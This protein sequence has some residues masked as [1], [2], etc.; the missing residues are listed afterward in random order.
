MNKSVVAAV[1][2]L[3][4][5]VVNLSLIEFDKIEE[6]GFAKVVAALPSLQALNLRGSTHVGERTIEAL[7][8][9]CTN[10]NT[11]NLNYTGILPNT[12][13]PLLQARSST[14]RVLKAAIPS[15]VHK[16]TSTWD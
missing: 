15:W 12:L 3:G 13:F 5:S 1:P 8:K 11:L 16:N 14:L 2:T 7:V 6:R 10:L 4:S 9:N